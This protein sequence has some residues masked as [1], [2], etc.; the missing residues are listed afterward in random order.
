M[1][2]GSA[3][4]LTACSGAEPRR[5]MLWWPVQTARTNQY[6]GER[7]R[8]ERGDGEMVFALPRATFPAWPLPV[9]SFRTRRTLRASSSRRV[10]H[11]SSAWTERVPVSFETPFSTRTLPR[12]RPVRVPSTRMRPTLVTLLRVPCPSFVSPFFKNRL[13]C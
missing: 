1:N 11:G 6:G 7:V 12:M 2:F 5:W 10:R 9:S 4:M 8:N 3:G 13:E